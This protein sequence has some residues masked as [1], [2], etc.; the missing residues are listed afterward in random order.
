MLPEQ[1]MSSDLLDILFADRNKLYG[2]YPLR[3]EYNK[4]LTK[5]LMLTGVLVVVALIG[6]YSSGKPK[7]FLAKT[8]FLDS[9]E[10][11]VIPPPKEPKPVAPPP[12]PI[13]CQ[14]EASTGWSGFVVLHESRN[15]KSKASEEVILIDELVNGFSF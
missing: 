10:T 13:F 1:I 6:Y 9:L 14:P 5:A 2:A 3:R 4:R 7:H 11:I 12:G 15:V 8:I